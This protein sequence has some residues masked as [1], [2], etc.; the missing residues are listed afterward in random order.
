MKTP[1]EVLINGSRHLIILGQLG[2][3]AVAL[4]RLQGALEDGQLLEVEEQAATIS[5]ELDYL[6]AIYPQKDG[7][8]IQGG[9]VV[10]RGLENPIPI[11]ETVREKQLKAQQALR[12]MRSL[13]D[14]AYTSYGVDGGIDCHLKTMY[15]IAWESA[16][17]AVGLDALD[18]IPF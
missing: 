17:K 2:N 11:N 10:K 15:D 13:I 16:A 5:G 4:E 9:S 7:S 12:D 3:I 18:D 6:Q 8:V 14:A 1:D